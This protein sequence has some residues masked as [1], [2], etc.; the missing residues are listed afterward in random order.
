MAYEAELPSQLGN[1]DYSLQIALFLENAFY[2]VWMLL[3]NQA[4]FASHTSNLFNRNLF[5]SATSAQT[6]FCWPT[7]SWDVKIYFLFE[8]A[9]YLIVYKEAIDNWNWICYLGV[10]CCYNRNL[11]LVM[12]ALDQQWIDAGRTSRR[13]TVKARKLRGLEGQ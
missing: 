1:L 6:G 8:V 12:L 9:K 11:K 7:K 4:G 5:Q 2:I 10:G 3:L 13:L